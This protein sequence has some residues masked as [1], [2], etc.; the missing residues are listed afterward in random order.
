MHPTALILDRH[1]QSL[2]SRVVYDTITGF[3]GIVIGVALHDDGRTECRVVPL[4]LKG[5]TPM[6]PVWLAI[7]RLE[8]VQDS[9][10]ELDLTVDA[11]GPPPLPGATSH[12]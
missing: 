6:D 4:A 8:A 3:R 10:Y 11:D 7:N 9:Q 5:G 2:A 1:L 12:E